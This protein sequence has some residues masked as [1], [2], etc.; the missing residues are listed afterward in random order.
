MTFKEAA[1]E[2]DISESSV[3][4]YMKR[5]YDKMSVSGKEELLTKLGTEQRE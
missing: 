3:K 2:L 4:T 1:R 5:I